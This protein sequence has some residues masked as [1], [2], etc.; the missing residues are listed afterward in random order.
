M[1]LMK[2]LVKAMM[3]IRLKKK[4]YEHISIELKDEID[5]YA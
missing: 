4:Y 5:F 2:I 3:K 1:F